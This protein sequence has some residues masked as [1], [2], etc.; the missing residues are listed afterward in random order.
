MY[1][2]VAS[3][4]STMRVR[5]GPE[6]TE[7]APTYFLQSPRRQSFQLFALDL[8]GTSKL[9]SNE[10]IRVK[11]SKLVD[12][13]SANSSQSMAIGREENMKRTN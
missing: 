1:S 7:M 10:V 4:S 2:L 8:V 9:L 5:D 6:G 3:V 13:S 12:G 11:R